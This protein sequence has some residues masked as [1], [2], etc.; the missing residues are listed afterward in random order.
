MSNFIFNK[1]GVVFPPYHREPSALEDMTSRQ[2]F[3]Y[4]K[5]DLEELIETAARLGFRRIVTQDIAR[6]NGKTDINQ[7]RI[8]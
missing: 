4:P 6:P 5:K 8:F 7:I 1:F 3:Q 2:W